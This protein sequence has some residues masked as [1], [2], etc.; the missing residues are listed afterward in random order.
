MEISHEL[1]LIYQI[2]QA[3]AATTKNLQLSE[4]RAKTIQD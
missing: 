3:Q 1:I 4:I 2:K